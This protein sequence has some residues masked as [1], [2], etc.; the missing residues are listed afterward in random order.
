MRLIYVE[1]DWKH[2][3]TEVFEHLFCSFMWLMALY[4]R[5]YLLTYLLTYWLM[6]WIVGD[7]E[8]GEVTA[9]GAETGTKQWNYFSTTEAATWRQR[10][11]PHLRWMHPATTSPRRTS[12]STTCLRPC[13]RTTSTLCFRPLARWKTASWFA[14]K[15]QASP[16]FTIDWLSKYSN[17]SLSL[18]IAAMRPNN[19]N[20]L[21][22]M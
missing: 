18:A 11:R 15:P 17:R 20:V 6:F 14:T 2:V 1:K 9:E 3:Y 12:S 19:N 7:R 22:N 4:E 5:F 16:R 21:T 8:N 13:H 10:I